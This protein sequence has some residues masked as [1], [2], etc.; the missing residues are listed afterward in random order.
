MSFG[1]LGIVKLGASRARFLPIADVKSA[2]RAEGR[3]LA[4]ARSRFVVVGPCSRAADSETRMSS[5][6]LV[7]QNHESHPFCVALKY[8]LQG[9]KPARSCARCRRPSV[10]RQAALCLN[11]TSDVSQRIRSHAPS[12]RRFAAERGGPPSPRVLQELG[13]DAETYHQLSTLQTR[14]ISP[15][16]YDLLLRLFTKTSTKTLSANALAKLSKHAFIA[17]S[18]LNEDCAVCL[19]M[20]SKGE[21][22]CRLP[23]EGRHV[24]HR[25]CILEWLSTSSR[26]CPCDQQ[27]LT[28]CCLSA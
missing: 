4:G 20:M 5:A 8:C 17:A 16:D 12:S 18:N 6:A 22:L 1:I 15:T 3:P 7:S 25:H 26:C 2:S 9:T 27:D 19:C 28:D 13:V 24:F 23:C 11:C 10:A 14:D 21:R